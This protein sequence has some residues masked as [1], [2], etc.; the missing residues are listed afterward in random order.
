M[1]SSDKSDPMSDDD[2]NRLQ[3]IIQRFEAAWKKGKRPRIVDYIEPDEPRR[4]DLLDELVHAELE[5]RLKAGEPARVEDYLQK[6]PSIARSRAKI[7]ELILAEWTFRRRRES[8]LHVAPYCARF[9]DYCAELTR[10]EPPRPLP[11]SITPTPRPL[12]VPPTPTADSVFPRRLGKFE[13][14]ENLGI[15]SFGV[16]YRAWDTVLDREVAIKV[17]R[18]ETLA[19]ATNLRTF[20]REARNA[21]HLRHPNIVPIHD[22]SPIDEIVCIVRAYID[23]ATLAQRLR[24]ERFS[25][26]ESAALLL[27]VLEALDYAHQ[28]GI[29]H[30]DLK[31]SNILLDQEGQPHVSDFGLAKSEA[32][33]S[34][35]CIPGQTRMT[36][37]GTP[38]Y[39]SPEQA[40]GEAYFVDARSDVYSVG[41]ILFELLTS[42]L[43]FRG[44][45]RMLLLQIQESAPPRPRLLN[46]DVPVD[47]ESIC[48]KALAKAPEDRYPTAKGMADELRDFLKGRPIPRAPEKRPKSWRLP[49]AVWLV[50]PLA[51]VV[52]LYIRAFWIRAEQRRSNDLLAVERAS[53]A[54]LE[55]ARTSQF[56]SLSAS[57]RVW[58]KVRQLSPALDGDPALLALSVE[59]ETELAHRAT[60]EGST[61]P[62][63]QHWGRAIER[64]EPLVR[65]GSPPPGSRENLAQALLALAK[66]QLSHGKVHEFGRL[67]SRSKQHLRELEREASTQARADRNDD[68]AQ[69]RAAFASLRLAEAEWQDRDPPDLA[70][71][72]T[73]VSRMGLRST[74]APTRI[75][76]L[77]LDLSHIELAAGQLEPAGRAARLSLRLLDESR[78]GLSP[79]ETTTGAILMVSRVEAALGHQAETIHGLTRAADALEELCQAEPGRL[80]TLR[81][82]AQARYELGQAL[83]RGGRSGPAIEAYRRSLQIRRQLHD[84]YPDSSTNLADLAETHRAIGAVRGSRFRA[85]PDDLQAIADQAR[86]FLLEPENPGH[87]R[88]LLQFV[89]KLTATIRVACK[90]F[91]WFRLSA[92]AGPPILREVETPRRR[93]DEDRRAP[94]GR[95]A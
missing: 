70:V 84:A 66:I 4:A 2:W 23:G 41:V 31:P 37:I 43:P 10:A 69:L 22:A 85:I 78:P 29:F 49:A 34:T 83:E 93:S 59:F 38:A 91:A 67:L 6:Y 17:P 39:M 80:E 95:P 63:E 68:E 60:L 35:L 15:G 82:L 30:R 44:Q 74:L 65:R 56:P 28:N 92:R 54:L 73:V 40:R 20:L 36:I 79:D 77:A 7:L 76:A 13:L 61:R 94:K 27:L 18:P 8:N 88:E 51:I 1:A 32:A 58:D 25:F 24:E 26:R 90:P 81:S 47:L 86:A 52:F 71:V 72:D 33:E 57:D 48:L 64:A 50:G 75:A 21:I 11:G 9:P 89:Q 62:A 12:N 53:R 19:S 14:R 16:V 3:A 87:R 42:A 5:F 55:L 45:G 46:E